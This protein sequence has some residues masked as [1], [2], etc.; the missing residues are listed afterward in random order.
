MQDFSKQLDLTLGEF[1]LWVSD[2][3]SEIEKKVEVLDT[4]VTKIEI[5]STIPTKSHT[6]VV[7][8]VVIIACLVLTLMSLY[9]LTR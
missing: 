6:K 4:R 5:M 7:W 1:R 9:Y 8:S 2:R 3:L